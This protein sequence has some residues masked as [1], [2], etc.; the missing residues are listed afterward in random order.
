MNPFDDMLNDVVFIVQASGKRQGPYKTALSSAGAQIF[1]AKLDVDEGDRLV[2]ALPNGKE[3]SY[4][5]LE[6]HFNQ[7]FEDIPAHFDL[8]LKK[9]SL[10][11]TPTSASR[12][13]TVHISNSTGV[14]V[15]D[16]NVLN[17]QNAFNDLIQRIEDSSGS[18][19]EKQE[20]KS[21]I[22]ALLTH[23]LVASILGGVAGNLPGMLGGG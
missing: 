22:A 13:T 16:N 10:M 3:D 11:T 6:A 20:V 2:R 4:A 19:G 18:D 9:G 1:D 17:I 7:Q 8:K 23:P 14:Q 12:S 15:G 5:V 21:R